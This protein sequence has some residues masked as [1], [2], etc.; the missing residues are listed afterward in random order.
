MDIKSPLLAA[1]F[2]A[3]VS[4]TNLVAIAPALGATPLPVTTTAV[5]AQVKYGTINIDGLDIA[6]R[7]AGDPIV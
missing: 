4:A 7:E 1:L 6:Y 2:S 5:A 3:A